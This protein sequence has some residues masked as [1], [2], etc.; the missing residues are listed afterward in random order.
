MD[1]ESLV[2]TWGG[3]EAST[4]QG[5]AALITPRSPYTVEGARS[6]LLSKVFR[7]PNRFKTKFEKEIKPN[8]FKTDFEK[9]L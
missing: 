6:H 4:F 8:R 1:P 2:I 7:S 9:N 5:V 3:I